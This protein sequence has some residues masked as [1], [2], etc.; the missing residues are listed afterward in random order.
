MYEQSG[1]AATKSIRIDQALLDI[2]ENAAEKENLSTNAFID[3][4]L[5]EYAEHERYLKNFPIIVL[6]YSMFNELINEISDERAEEL[7]GKLGAVGPKSYML[8]RGMEISLES[9][10]KILDRNYG[11]GGGWFDPHIHKIDDSVMLHL[12]HRYGVKWS[13]F[14]AGYLRAMFKELFEI[15][16]KIDIADSYLTAKI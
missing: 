3:R 12:T 15:E 13:R 2:L 10:L 4:L 1:L 16:A 5:V 6:S 7:G 14:L 8:M 9:V 11:K